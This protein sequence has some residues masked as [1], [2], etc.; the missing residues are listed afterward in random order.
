MRKVL[1]VL[2][3]LTLAACAGLPR[4]TEPLSVTLAD[5]RP[6]QM[7]LLEQEYAMKIRVQ[8]PNNVDIPL[9]GVSFSVDLN[10]KTFAKGVSRQDTSVPAFGDVLLDV[11]AISTLGDLLNQVSAMRQEG[12]SKIT[13]R[14]Q[15]KLSPARGISTLPFESVGNLDLA[16]LTAETSK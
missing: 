1:A 7:G 3:L 6:V 11:K 2:G 10:G 13:Y 8:N 14:L 4:G 5:V 12:L 15:G 16:G 9:A